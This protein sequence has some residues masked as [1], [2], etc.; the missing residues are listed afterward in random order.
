[1]INQKV[2][3]LMTI[4]NHERYIKSAINSLINQKFKNW[5]LIAIDNGSKD[6]SGLILK[7]FKD[8]RIKKKFFKKNIGRTRCLN[9]VLKFCKS[10]YIAILDSD[11]ISHKNRLS[12]QIKELENNK[13]LGLVFTD[14]DFIDEKSNR[15]FISKKKFQFKNIRELLTKN[16]IGHS[17]VMYKRNILKKVG[18]YPNKYNY[19]QDYA[20]YLKILKVSNIKFIKK[21]LVQI[22]IP[23]NNSET[24][25]ILNSKLAIIERIKIL[26]SN[27]NNFKTSLSEKIMIFYLINIEIIKF[28]FPNFIYKTVR[29]MKAF[30]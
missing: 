27:L 29:F 15:I 2:S 3:I 25:R 4:Y 5:E 21:K 17:T 22:R 30:K 23:H 1:M 14:F 26:F 20:F 24:K 10:K 8:K 12:T 16:F 11:D 7:N 6:K 13:S 28:I 9:Y 18:N 19:A